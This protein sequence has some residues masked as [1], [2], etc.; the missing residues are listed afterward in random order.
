MVLEEGVSLLYFGEFVVGL[1]GVG[2]VG[3]ELLYDEGHFAEG[4]LC[5]V[6]TYEFAFVVGGQFVDGG[7]EVVLDELHGKHLLHVWYY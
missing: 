3:E 1:A 6:E 7:F 2:L 4:G 5:L